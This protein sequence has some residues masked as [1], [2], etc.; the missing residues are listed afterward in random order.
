MLTLLLAKTYGQTEK[1][2][3]IKCKTIN[4]K[5]YDRNLNFETCFAYCVSTGGYGD[6]ELNRDGHG[7]CRC[8]Y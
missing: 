1:W 5:L 6:C 4:Q 3:G 7:E 2:T 8:E